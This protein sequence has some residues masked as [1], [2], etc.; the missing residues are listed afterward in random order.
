MLFVLPDS[1]RWQ[2]RDEARD[3][4]SLSV[5]IAPRLAQSVLAH[6]AGSRRDSPARDRTSSDRTCY[7]RRR[8]GDGEGH[9]P[10]RRK[11]TRPRELRPARSCPWPVQSSRGSSPTT[12]PA[13]ALP[14]SPSP[15]PFL[16]SQS[17]TVSLSCD[18]DGIPAG[19]DAASDAV[20]GRA[21]PPTRR[22]RARERAREPRSVLH[23]MLAPDQRLRFARGA[24][25]P[26]R[27][28]GR[29][30]R[31]N[32]MR[33]REAGRGWGGGELNI[34]PTDWVGHPWPS[35]GF[36]GRGQMQALNTRQHTHALSSQALH[37]GS[38]LGRHFG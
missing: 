12:S 1:Q 7:S 16:L 3:A 28:R 8:R 11:G 37:R 27:R 23:R 34:R 22:E 4:P 5:C 35:Q 25:S 20:R 19:V 30:M 18:H 24:D 26:G 33:N 2:R 17:S 14:H 6:R 9:P 32:G 36:F 10:G 21:H 13:P 31:A 29:A 38:S 15:P